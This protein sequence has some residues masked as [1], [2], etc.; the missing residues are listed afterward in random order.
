M[1]FSK[2][3]L[4]ATDLDGTLLNNKGEVSSRFF[5]LFKQL[6]KQNIHFVA[7][8]GRQFQSIT[9]KLNPIKE[10]ISI[11]AENG[12]V[13]Q[14]NGKVNSL[15]KLS[16]EDVLMAVNTLRS[17]KNCYIV[18]CGKE[19][20]YIETDNEKFISKFSEYYNA[21][22]IVDDLTK[23]ENDD[24][25]KIAVYHFKSSENYILPHISNITNKL[26]VTVSGKNWLDISH[27]NA[28]KGY[29]LNK[30]QKKLGITE[31]ETMVFG[32]YNNDIEMLQLA[33]FSYAMKNAHDNV[34][35]VARY[36]TLSN[37]N[38]GV[39]QILDLL[40]KQY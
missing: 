12:G 22:Y 33:H 30:L 8:S 14:F 34:K 17:I 3:K 38:E 11:I 25:L 26:K 37:N 18:L 1:D 13:I 40:L 19:Y 24:F 6:K 21:Y 4:I 39:E 20:A 36:E 27:I 10:D 5:N 35:E 7:A 28:N 23:V 15:L 16:S 32:D 2:V 9:A 31:E 29:A